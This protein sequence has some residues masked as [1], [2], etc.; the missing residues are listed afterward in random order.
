MRQARSEP[1]RWLWAKWKN[2]GE[3]LLI[4]AL[5]AIFIRTFI[6]G[7]YK[8]PTGSMKPTFMEHDKIF[9]DKL[10]Y[11]FRPPERGDIIVFKYPLDR[12]KDFVK[13]LVGL[14]GDTVEIRNGVILVNGNPMTEPPFGVHTY[15][16]TEDWDYGKSGQV[17]RV[18]SD[19]FFAL[20]DNS[21]HSA[22]SRQW[23]FVPKKDLIGKAF[24]IW[25]PPR[26]IQLAR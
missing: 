8:I 21:A 20:G 2:W 15:Y 11:R 26:R 4:A 17:V 5:L 23:G 14:P 3:P 6:F 9:V 16:N 25:W 1:K 12:K 13:R 7:P 24:M 10:S 19:H 18:P 22:D